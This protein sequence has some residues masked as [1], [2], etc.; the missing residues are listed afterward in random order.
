MTMGHY[1]TFLVIQCGKD[2]SNKEP[3]NLPFPRD[4]PGGHYRIVVLAS[5]TSVP[6]SINGRC[7]WER[8]SWFWWH[9]SC[10]GGVWSPS[11]LLRNLQEF[12][13]PI[14]W[15]AGGLLLLVMS[16]AVAHFFL[17]RRKAAKDNINKT[18]KTHCIPLIIHHSPQ[19]IILHLN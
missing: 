11:E 13:G 16:C 3:C 1:S 18:K 7:S 12:M 2:R 19:E 6:G 4:L 14:Y 15:N 8:I 10:V 5:P 17:C 9:C